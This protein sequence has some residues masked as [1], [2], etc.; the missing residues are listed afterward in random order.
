MIRFST[1]LTL[2]AFRNMLDNQNRN[3]R[4]RDDRVFHVKFLFVNTSWQY[5]LNVMYFYFF[6]ILSLLQRRP[7]IAPKNRK[8]DGYTRG[9]KVVKKTARGGVGGKRESTRGLNVRAEKMSKDLCR[10]YNRYSRSYT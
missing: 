3:R 6:Y 2:P 9:K 10:H 4:R 1:P 5:I 7:D 8:I